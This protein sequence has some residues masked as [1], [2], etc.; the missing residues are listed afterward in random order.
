MTSY[1]Y[2]KCHCGYKTIL[3]QSYLQNGI[4][5]TCKTTSL[6]RIRIQASLFDDYIFIV[7]WILGCK[8]V[9]S[10]NQC[11]VMIISFQ[12]IDNSTVCST[13]CWGW[14]QRKH[15]S[16]ELLSVCKDNPQETGWG[17]GGALTRG[18]LCGNRFDVKR[19]YDL[20]AIIILDTWLYPVG[21]LT[22]R[23]RVT[24]ICVSKL[25]YHWF[26]YGL[27]HEQSHRPS[28][29]PMLDCCRIIDYTSTLGIGV[30]LF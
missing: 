20:T 6:Y 28:S 24:N 11:T 10:R 27:A 13:A 14:L 1:Q 2:R 16:S 12:I 15:Q 18:Q 23:S 9:V 5:I 22:Y 26:W 30:L 8:F 21:N 29:K 17:G 25:D 4:S 19:F 3:G 7:T